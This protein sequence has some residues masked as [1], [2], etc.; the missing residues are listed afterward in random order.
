VTASNWLAINSALSSG[1]GL[2][3]HL[4]ECGI[5]CDVV[6][7]GLAPSSP[8]D[9]IKTDW[10]DS[11]KL[12]P[13]ETIHVPSPELEALRDLVRA[14]ED[15]RLDRMRASHRLSKLMLRHGR[16]LPGHS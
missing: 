5:V 6:A 1:F 16:L 9:R 7:S 8:G 15:A 3:R 11:R 14:R 10:R 13:L 12:A 4:R 2:Y